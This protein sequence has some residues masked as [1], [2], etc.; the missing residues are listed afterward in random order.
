MNKPKLENNS[1]LQLVEGLGGFGM[2]LDD[3]IVVG[4][5]ADILASCIMRNGGNLQGKARALT[6][7]QWDMFPKY[8][9]KNGKTIIIWHKMEYYHG[10][11]ISSSEDSPTTDFWERQIV[12]NM[13]R[14]LRLGKILSL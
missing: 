11:K 5:T 1:L 10:H 2:F 12:F 4:N 9:L 7:E 6:Q 3:K 13:L 14:A 8:N